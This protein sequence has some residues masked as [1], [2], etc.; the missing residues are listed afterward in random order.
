M[1]L[2]VHGSDT[3]CFLEI[4]NRFSGSGS[5][6]IGGI[7]GALPNAWSQLSQVHTMRVE[8]LSFR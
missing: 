2:T 1:L 7:A 5:L 4:I 8:I 6:S 3:L